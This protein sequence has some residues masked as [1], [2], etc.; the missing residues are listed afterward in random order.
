MLELDGN[1]ITFIVT[2]SKGFFDLV[3]KLNLDEQLFKEG[4]DSEGN[5]I[6]FYSEATEAI[7][8][9]KKAGTPFTL[10]DSGEFFESFDLF[11]TPNEIFFSAERDFQNALPGEPGDIF[12]KYGIEI[13]GLTDENF[14]R[15]TEFIKTQLFEIILQRLFEGV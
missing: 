10:K 15:V 13:L 9:S 2:D 12:T 7:N 6:G 14:E 1:S 5:T 4:I 11:V 8:P 3:K